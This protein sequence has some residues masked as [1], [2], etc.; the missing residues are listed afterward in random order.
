MA[1]FENVHGITRI[2][3]KQNIQC[4]CPLGNDYYTNQVSVLFVPDEVIPDYCEV[5][6]YMRKM[7]GNKY[8]VEDTVFMVFD[9]L[10][11]KYKPKYLKVTSYADDAVHFEV[12]VTKETP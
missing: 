7:S 4:F 9:Y 5:E 8:T 2:K 1:R 11:T 6:Q 3:F 10:N 12:E